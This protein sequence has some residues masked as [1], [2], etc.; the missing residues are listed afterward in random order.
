VAYFEERKKKEQSGES[1][2]SLSRK[3][4]HSVVLLLRR[5]V[6]IVPDEWREA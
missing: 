4:N 6:F 3:L 5:K 2:N 1:E